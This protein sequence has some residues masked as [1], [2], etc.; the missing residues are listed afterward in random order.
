MKCYHRLRVPYVCVGLRLWS[1]WRICVFDLRQWRQGTRCVKVVKR[2]DLSHVIL[3][4]VFSTPTIWPKL[5]SIN[6]PRQH[7]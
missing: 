7:N 4:L 1:C 6:K 3:E 2:Q 5:Q